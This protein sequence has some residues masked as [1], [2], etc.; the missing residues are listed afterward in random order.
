MR[1]RP[2]RAPELREATIREAEE[3][4]V[5]L[6]EP[7]PLGRGERLVLPELA[8]CQVVAV[9]RLAQVEVLADCPR[10]PVAV[11][12]EDDAHGI[13]GVDEARDEPARGERLVIGMWCEDQHPRVRRQRER[14]DRRS[15]RHRGDVGA[16]AERQQRGQQE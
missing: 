2:V 12:D 15:L 1:P 5:A 3:R 10:V 13:P 7:E 9:G 4:D 14:L 6:R 8:E 11:G 16:D